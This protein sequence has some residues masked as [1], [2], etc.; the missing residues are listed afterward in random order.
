MAGMWSDAAKQAA[1][2][3]FGRRNYRTLAFARSL[4]L[5]LAVAALALVVTGARW[6]WMSVAPTVAT[7]LPT[8][9][10]IL[11][12]AAAAA[13]TLFV[14]YRLATRTR[15]RGYRMPRRRY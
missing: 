9:L 8:G 6:L 3:E 1:E 2:Q 15:R 14:L 7:W 10:G 11:A 4:P 5:I 13:V 12:L